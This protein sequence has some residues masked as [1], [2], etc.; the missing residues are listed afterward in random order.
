MPLFEYRCKQCH[1]L[2]EEL[3]TSS[4]TNVLCPECSSEHVEKMLSTFGVGGSS[5]P[6]AG[7]SCGVPNPGS[8]CGTHDCPC[9]N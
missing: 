3:V 4:Q 2:F 1:T 6:C 9:L 5:D 7:G 8:M